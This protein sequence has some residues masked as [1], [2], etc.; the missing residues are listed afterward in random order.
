MIFDIVVIVVIGMV[1][2]IDVILIK[3]VSMFYYKEVF[4]LEEYD[5]C[6]WIYVS[7]FYIGVW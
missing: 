1:L 5:K 3:K 6:L 7:N 4:L 2:N